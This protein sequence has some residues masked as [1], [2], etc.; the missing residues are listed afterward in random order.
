MT[1]VTTSEKLVRY[2]GAARTE[3]V[4]FGMMDVDNLTQDFSVVGDSVVPG[5]LSI[6]GIGKSAIED[7]EGQRKYAHIEEFINTVGPSKKILERLIKLGAFDRKHKNRRALWMFW[8]FH[9]GKDKQHTALKR[10]LRVIWCW[11]PQEIAA[12]RQRQ[13]S[14]YFGLHPKRTKIPDKIRNWV[15]SEPR[16]EPNLNVLSRLIKFKNKLWSPTDDDFFTLLSQNIKT[17]ELKPEAKSM[18][19]T[20]RKIN[21]KRRHLEKLFPETYSL[22]EI[23]DFEMEY[24][25]YYWHSP[26]DVYHHRGHTSVERSKSSGRLEAIIDTIEMCQGKR[27]IYARVYVTDGLHRARIMVWE[28]FLDDNPGAFVEKQAVS[29]KVKWNDKFR[30]FNLVKGSSVKVLRKKKDVTILKRRDS[31]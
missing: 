31:V 2:M 19:H 22:E 6:K 12:E 27:S 21:L 8:L 26:L 18:W 13:A 29:M 16:K 9:F 15:P 4:K 3:E 25:G 24:L 10:I 20:A 11:T 1:N 5:L 17:L 28:D 23:L 30:S 14:A 7:I